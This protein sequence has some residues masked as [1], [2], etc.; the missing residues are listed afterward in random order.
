ME[1]GRAVLSDGSVRTGLDLVTAM[2]E[3]VNPA[4]SDADMEAIEEAACPTCGSCAG[5]FTANSMNCLL[6]ALGLALPGN[7]TTL[8]T[9]TA[10]GALYEQAGRTVV[11]RRAVLRQGRRDRAAPGDRLAGG[12]R[13]RDGPGPGH[14]RPTNTVLHLLAAAQRL[15][16]TTAWPTSTPFARGAVPVQGGPQQRVPDGGRPSGRR[17]SRSPG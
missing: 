4:V 7:G 11:E 1:G 15:N 13:Q 6:E 14:G 8:A 3:A 16:W 12:V 10:R 17:R 5:M 2:S 9:H